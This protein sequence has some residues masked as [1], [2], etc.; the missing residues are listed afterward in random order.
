MRT[1]RVVL[2]TAVLTTVI[3]AGAW[4]GRAW[5]DP[6]PSGPLRVAATEADIEAIVN[7]V[8]GEDVTTFHLF[9]GCI[10]RA[11]LEVRAEV[12]QQLAGAEAIVWTG[13][14]NE[15]RAVQAW[16]DG[17]PAE[18][19]S[20]LQTPAWIDVS[21]GVQRVNVPVSACDG[22][23]EL[24]YMP[25]DPFFWLNPENGAV[26]ARNVA[27]GLSQLRPARRA[28]Y[29]ANADTFNRDLER[30]IEGWKA[31]LAPLDA[32]KVFS[33]QCG[34]QNLSRLGGPHFMACRKNPGQ[35]RPP[36]E[37][38]AQ[39]APL[40]LDVIIVDPN[41]PAGYAEAFRAATAAEVVVIPSSIADLAG[42]RTYHSLFDS[43]V[44]TL[45]GTVAGKRAVGGAGGA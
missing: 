10:L 21:H 17:L 20:I 24:Q 4:V 1:R 2:F 5:P 6:S 12:E 15:S 44:A 18:R 36:D 25:G 14:F 19:R 35:L 45:R 32:L 30:R 37:L 33:A 13:F 3:A 28:Y 7:A 43:I 16:L 27:E 38:A 34:W 39:L 26:I 11:D 22:Y 23:L 9:R 8:G 41:T 29:E 31:E 40:G 42:A